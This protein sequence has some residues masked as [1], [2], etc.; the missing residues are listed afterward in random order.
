MWAASLPEGSPEEDFKAIK[1]FSSTLRGLR[2]FSQKWASEGQFS[3]GDMISF[4]EARKLSTADGK[5]GLEGAVAR[6]NLMG[7]VNQFSE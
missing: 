6:W 7:T 2:A 4:I 5:E 1:D 3:L